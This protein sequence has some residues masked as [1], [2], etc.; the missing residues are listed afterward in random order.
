[1]GPQY[2]PAAFDGLSRDAFAAAMRAEG[3]AID[4]GFRSLEAIHSPRRF[5]TT[6]ELANAR[7][8][9]RRILTLHHPVLLG[10][11]NDIG[12]IAAALDKVR[13]FATMLRE[14]AERSATVS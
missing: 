7:D 13:R 12:E 10:S 11:E 2:D 8:A 9:D 3:I 1:V 6:G 14:Q 5:R 4:S